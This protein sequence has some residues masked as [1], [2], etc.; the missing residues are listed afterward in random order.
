MYAKV[1]NGQVTQIGLPTT[2]T[3]KDGRTVSNYNLLPNDILI[4]EGWLPCEEI[5]P[6]IT[7]KQYLEIDTKEIVKG[8]VIVTYKVVEMPTF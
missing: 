4:K 8:K 7:E 2:G 6:E 3:L 5:K 1:E